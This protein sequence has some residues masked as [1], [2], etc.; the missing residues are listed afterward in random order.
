MRSPRSGSWLIKQTK[1]T[2]WPKPQNT[3]SGFYCV[4][5]WCISS[6]PNCASRYIGWTQLIQPHPLIARVACFILCTTGRHSPK[7]ADHFPGFF[8]AGFAYILGFDNFIY[9]PS[10]L[11]FFN[12]SRWL[13][14]DVKW[15]VGKGGLAGKRHCQLGWPFAARSCTNIAFWE[16]SPSARNRIGNFSLQRYDLRCKVASPKLCYSL[17]RVTSLLIVQEQHTGPVNSV[18]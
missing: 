7:E 2:V 4:T 16:T 17:D 1:A 3:E 9:A 10:D 12:K 14:S 5:E 11:R 13:V 8:C 15:H 18:Q 6:T